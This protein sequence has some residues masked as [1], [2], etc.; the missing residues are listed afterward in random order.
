LLPSHCCLLDGQSD[1]LQAD[2]GPTVLDRFLSLY[3]LLATYYLYTW[4]RWNFSHEG[5][6]LLQIVLVRGPKNSVLKPYS[7]RGPLV[8]VA[9]KVLSNRTTGPGSRFVHGKERAKVS[10]QRMKILCGGAARRTCAT[11]KTYISSTRYFFIQL[12]MF[13]MR[14][15]LIGWLGFAVSL[16]Y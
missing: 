8:S 10:S 13:E 7:I 15:I 14:A 4:N 6:W 2:W 12:P 3:L 1:L 11:P 5:I 16:H 9:N